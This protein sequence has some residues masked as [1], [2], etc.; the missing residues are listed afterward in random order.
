M[1]AALFNVDSVWLEQPK[2]KCK[3]LGHDV[4]SEFVEH[5]GDDLKGWWAICWWC[6]TCGAK[7]YQKITEDEYVNHF[8]LTEDTQE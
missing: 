4:E 6:N 5:W 7:G 3:S 8:H 2:Q 1:M